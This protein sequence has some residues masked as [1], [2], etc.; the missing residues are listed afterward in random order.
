M[1][2]EEYQNQMERIDRVAERLRAKVKEKYAMA[3]AKARVGDTVT[4]HRCTIMVKRVAVSPA[5]F[6]Y[7]EC[8][9][10]GP[11]LTKKGVPYKNGCEETVCDCNVLSVREGWK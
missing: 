2:T 3:H 9:Y 4:D 5:S 7:P 6:F 1:T 8:R 11:K 10:Y